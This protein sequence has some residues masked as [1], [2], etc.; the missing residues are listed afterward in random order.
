MIRLRDVSYTYPFHARAALRNVSLDVEPGQ[1]VL[2]AGHS[3]GGKTTILRLINGLIP[4]LHCGTLS[5]S[6]T[7]GATETRHQSLQEISNRIA[8]LFQDPEKQFLALNVVDE[9]AFALEWQKVQAPEAR[10]RVEKALDEFGLNDIRNASVYELSEG[11]KQKVALASLCVLEPKVLVLDEPT[12]NLD[13]QASAELG[14]QLAR[15]K[16]RG[17][18]LVIADHRLAWLRSLIDK[19]YVV[20][21]GRI[22]SSGSW[23]ILEDGQL[24]RQH[25]LRTVEMPRLSCSQPSDD[26][27]IH[28]RWEDLHF[29]YSRHKPVFTGASLSIPSGSVAALVGPNGSG[30]TTLAKLM[31]GLLKPNRGALSRAGLVVSPKQLLRTAGMA[32]QNSDLQLYRKTARQEVTCVH[33]ATARRLTLQKADEWLDRFGLLEVADRHPQ[34]L[35][36]GQK[37]R[38]VVA[39]AAARAQDLLILDEP[40][41]GLDG[42]QMRALA[43]MLEERKHEGHTSLVI[44]H[45]IELMA[46]VCTHQIKLTP[47]CKETQL[48]SIQPDAVKETT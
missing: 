27:P 4:H 32:M 22:V 40:T 25:G 36:G 10:K 30:K 5:G 34:S 31:A 28:L 18:T 9:V 24:R 20:S 12:A 13:P 41:S 21:G 17:I 26:R 48:H 16:A 19:V 1:A 37:Q 47:D 44:T 35:S 7:I 29:A 14:R 8:T 15:L 38:L 23:S 6:V 45:D 3:G 33:S 43:N 42:A 46:Q 11:Q 2:L 39:C